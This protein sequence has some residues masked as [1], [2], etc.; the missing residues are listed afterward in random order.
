MPSRK[1]ILL[2]AAGVST[3]AITWAIFRSR[4]AEAANPKQEKIPMRKRR[5]ALIGDSQTARELGKAFDQVFCDYASVKYYGKPGATHVQYLRNPS[6]LQE[7]KNMSPADAVYIQLGDNGVPGSAAQIKEFA[8]YVKRLNPDARI[9]WGGPMRPVAPTNGV[10]TYVSLDPNSP[11][12]LPTYRNSMRRQADRL[13]DALEGTD[14]RYIDNYRIQESRPREAAF[15][16]S[17][18]GDGVH[19]TADSAYDLACIARE[20]VDRSF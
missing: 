17:R 12:Y 10:E 18:G 5:I 3:L 19:L 7:I 2:S 20:A 8:N 11:R 1:A 13:R 9:F 4:S 6:L 16:D 14:V 15:S